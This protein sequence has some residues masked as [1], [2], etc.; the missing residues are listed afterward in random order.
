MI[1]AALLIPTAFVAGLFT[2]PPVLGLPLVIAAI[3]YAGALIGWLEDAG[4]HD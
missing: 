4:A 3:I 2:L 1:S